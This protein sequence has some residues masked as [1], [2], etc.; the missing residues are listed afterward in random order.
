MKINYNLG[1][2]KKKQV[3]KNLKLEVPFNRN[4][5]KWII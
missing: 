5:G 4:K 1:N 2:R 3:Y